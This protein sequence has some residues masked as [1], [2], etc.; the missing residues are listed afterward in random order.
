MKLSILVILFISFFAFFLS[1][2]K[3]NN[4]MIAT[5]DSIHIDTFLLKQSDNGFLFA[6]DTFAVIGADTI[7]ITLPGFSNINS[8]YLTP[9]IAF[10]GKSI[11]PAS[12]VAQD[13]SKPVTYSVFGNENTKRNYVVQTILTSKNELLVNGSRVYALDLGTGVARWISEDNYDISFTSG[14]AVANGLVYSGGGDGVLYASDAVTGKVAWSQHL[15]SSYLCTP[16][17]YNGLVYT[18][19]GDGNLYAANGKTGAMKWS[20]N[21]NE[22]YGVFTTPS[23]INNVLYIQCNQKFY[24]LNASTGDSIWA[25]SVPASF[26]ASAAIGSSL[27]YISGADSNMY[28]IDLASGNTAWSFYLGAGGTSPTVSGGVVYEASS[29]D[30]LFAIDAATGIKKWSV[31]VDTGPFIQGLSYPGIQSNPVVYNNTVYIGGGDPN[32]YAFDTGTGAL[33]WLTT[34]G[35][36][37]RFGITC[38]NGIIYASDG[39]IYAV[40]AGTG[41]IKWQQTNLGT[42]QTPCIIGVDG[43]VYNPLN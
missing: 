40:D 41:K 20:R 6:T 27:A 42:S 10:T 24:A 16:A 13:F 12:G 25:S 21:F 14:A 7:T 34:L 33:K 5:P 11:S 23:I 19:C 29:N 38:V 9:T 36:E 35:N 15:G 26:Y 18:G 30:S 37:I 43:T 32:L 2:C 39:D 22:P 3:K 28:A 31:Y 8:F 17:V 1:A 4:G